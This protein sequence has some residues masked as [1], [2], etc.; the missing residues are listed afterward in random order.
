[1]TDDFVDI[2]TNAKE[3]M[4]LVDPTFD[5]GA[6]SD[7]EEAPAALGGVQNHYSYEG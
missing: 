4:M 2:E 1:L 3:R 5:G 6:E 7:D